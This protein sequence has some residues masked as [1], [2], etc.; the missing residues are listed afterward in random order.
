MTD[1]LLFD[2]SD[3][4]ATITFNNPDRLN[5]FTHEMLTGYLDRLEECDIDTIP[6]SR[7]KASDHT[8]VWCR[9]GPASQAADLFQSA[10]GDA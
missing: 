8:P 4:I 7:P 10:T 6:R 3:R 9:L 5:A 1:K 2:V